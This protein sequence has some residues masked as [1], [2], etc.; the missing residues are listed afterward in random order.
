M[1]MDGEEACIGMRLLLGLVSGETQKQ[2]RPNPD[3]T[4][5]QCKEKEHKAEAAR[6]NSD[7]EIPINHVRYSR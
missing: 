7:G 3:K 4:S 6:S 2:S 5:Q 1:A